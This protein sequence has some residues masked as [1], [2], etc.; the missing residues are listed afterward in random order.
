M[1]SMLRGLEAVHVLE[2]DV[3]EQ[4]TDLLQRLHIAERGGE[5]QLIAIRGELAKYPFGIGGLR[6]V[7]HKCG[8]DLG[9]ECLFQLQAGLIVHL[10]PAA[11]FDRAQINETHLER[12]GGGGR[13]RRCNDQTCGNGQSERFPSFV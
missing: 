12:L 10:G 4:F 7:F 8:L 13:H 2:F 6:N 1:E 9:A 5:Y 11:V 3:R